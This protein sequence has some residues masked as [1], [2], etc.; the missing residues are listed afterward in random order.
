MNEVPPVVT[1]QWIADDLGLPLSTVHTYRKRAERNRRSRAPRPGDLPPADAPLGR[2]P[3][4]RRETYLA[5][6]ASRPGRGAGGGP[7][8][9]G[10][11]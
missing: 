1:M 8:R 2:T 4:W 9:Q 5:W 6:K 11:Q 3:G 10:N 7:R